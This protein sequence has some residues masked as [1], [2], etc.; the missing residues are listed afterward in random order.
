MP[1]S[2]TNPDP[3]FH[4]QPTSGAAAVETT[5]VVSHTTTTAAPAPSH[6]VE[7]VAREPSHPV[8]SGPNTTAT[9][10]S[11]TSSADPSVASDQHKA[12]TAGPTAADK[13]AESTGDVGVSGPEGGAGEKGEGGLPPQL[14]AGKTGLGPHYNGGS[15]LADSL[16]AKEEIIKGKLKHDPSL[17]Q[18]GHDRQSGALAASYRE[19]KAAEEEK[20]S[21]F[22]RPDD[23]AVEGQEKPPGAKKTSAEEVRE[24]GHAANAS[25][26]TAGTKEN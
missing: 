12:G 10:A 13:P 15:G 17:V 24:S 23:G 26:A 1:T 16:K 22:A 14:H 6:P 25:A 21:P 2:H 8:S 11:T 4:H 5:P 20:E 3:S 19:Q 7:P 9:P 18:Q